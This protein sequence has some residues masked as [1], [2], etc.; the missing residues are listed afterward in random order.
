MIRQYNAILGRLSGEGIIPEGL[1][2]PLSEQDRLDEA[3]VACQQLCGYLKGL[4]YGGGLT[5]Q[6]RDLA[7]T[8]SLREAGQEIRAILKRKGPG[9]VAEALRDV[10]ARIERQAGA[11]EEE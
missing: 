1:F 7:P 5:E 4:A 3:G 11:A 8:D 2:S 9:E 6:P 10:A